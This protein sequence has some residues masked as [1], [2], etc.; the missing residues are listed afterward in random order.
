MTEARA[1]DVLVASSL[2][3]HTRLLCIC[4]YH[5][6]VTAVSMYDW[7]HIPK[8]LRYY[9]SNVEDNEAICGSGVLQ[10]Y[11]CGNGL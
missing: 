10:Y 8:I 1:A 7:K 6:M 2:L 9:L 3:W 11:S 5:E 4:V